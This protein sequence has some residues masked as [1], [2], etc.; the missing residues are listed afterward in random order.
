MIRQAHELDLLT[1]PYVFSADE[2]V[3]MTEAGADLIVPHMGVTTGGTIGATTPKCLE[4]SGP[5]DRR[6]GR[7]GPQGAQG[8]HCHCA[9]RAHRVAGRRGLVFKHSEHCN[10]FYG[11]SS[12]ERLPTEI[13]I[14]AYRDVTK[15][16]I[17]KN[18]GEKRMARVYV[19]AVMNASWSRHGLSCATLARC[20]LPSAFL[21]KRHRRRQA[22]RP[23]GLRAPISMRTTAATCG[24]SCWRC[25]TRTRLRYRI[26]TS[27][28]TGVT[29]TWP[30]CTCCRLPKVTDVRRVVGRIRRGRQ[31]CGRRGTDLSDTFR[32]GLRGGGESRERKEA[33]SRAAPCLIHAYVIGT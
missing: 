24:R 26:L 11:A 9:R 32:L 4:D 29:I 30:R 12:M 5:A 3:A 23:G 1:T 17:L 22:L 18:Q 19:S 20:G 2:A 16:G 7:S 8:C 31:R 14:T 15:G 33:C 6:M 28:R 27:T 13:A 10:G 21:R 25:P